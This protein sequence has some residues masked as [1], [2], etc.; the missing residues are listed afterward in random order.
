MTSISSMELAIAYKIH[1]MSLPV[2]LLNINTF[3]VNICMW[4]FQFDVEYILDT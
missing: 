1:H 4:K 2:S 3:G